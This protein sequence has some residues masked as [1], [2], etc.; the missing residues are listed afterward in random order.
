MI[1]AAALTLAAHP[2]GVRRS[3]LWRE[4]RQALPDLEHQYHSVSE[5]RTPIERRFAFSSTGL[6]KA[7]WVRKVNG[8][9][10]LT[11]VG[12]QA[13]Q[14]CQEASSFYDRLDVLYSD[15]SRNRARFDQAARLI[16]ALPEG[17]WVS[18]REVAAVAALEPLRLVQWLQGTRPEGWY[19]VLDADGGL[20]DE[21]GLTNCTSCW[22]TAT[23]PS[24]CSTAP[25]RARASAC[26]AT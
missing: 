24:A 7:G 10:F 6:A 23:R 12:R 3:H 21:L 9:W 26:R 1:F 22:S 18:A 8:V 5:G 15:W 17:S 19:R 4:I 13:L 11:A 14:E 16:E 25:T 2:E 20:P